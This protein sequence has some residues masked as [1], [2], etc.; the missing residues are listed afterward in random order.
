[1][2]DTTGQLRICNMYSCSIINIM[3]EE[4]Y[5]VHDRNRYNQNKYLKFNWKIYL[6]GTQELH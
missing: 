5:Y 4:T 1:M 6:H 3:H 2:V